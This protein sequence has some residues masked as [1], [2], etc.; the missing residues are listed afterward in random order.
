MPKIIGVDLD[1]VLF[2]CNEALCVWH[3]LNY[4]TSYAK[5]DVVS[6]ELK[7]VWGCTETEAIARVRQFLDS[8]EHSNALTVQG[9]V[10]GLRVLGEENCHIVT[11]RA[12]MFSGPTTQWLERHFPKMANRVH[13]VGSEYGFIHHEEIKPATCKRLG[14]DVFI[15]DSLVHASG[16]SKAGIPVLLLDN[17]W[18][19]TDKLPLNVE[20]VYSWDEIVERL[21]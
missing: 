14:I 7:Y 6:Y 20:R 2:A 1:D 3:N 5:E 19:Q 16:V 18:N 9:A 12:Q 15:D 11:A 17:P 8:F 13:F 4:G 10:E 21:R